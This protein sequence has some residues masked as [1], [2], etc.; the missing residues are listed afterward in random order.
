MIKEVREIWIK[1]GELMVFVE[2]IDSSGEIFVMVFLIFYWKYCNLFV[3][4]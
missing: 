4:D 3:V 1:K 2:G